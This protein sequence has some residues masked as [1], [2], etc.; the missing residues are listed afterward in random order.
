MTFEGVDHE[1][2]TEGGYEPTM[3]RTSRGPIEMHHYR[4]EHARKAAIFVGGAGG[5]FDTPWRGRLYPVLCR[6]FQQEG[7]VTCLRVRYRHPADLLECTLDVLA[8]VDFLQQQGVARMAV[9]GWSFGGAV[10]VQAA[11]L[12]ERVRTVVTVAT[13]SYGIDAV[14]ELGPRCSVLLLHGQAD[15]TLPSRCSEYAH[16]IAREPKKLIL[17]PESNHG[18]DQYEA[19]P[20]TVHG[21]IT[22]ELSRT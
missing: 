1:P 2:R 8:G 16:Q 17:D 6:Q 19:M 18:L 12:A 22:G 10:V 13:Q 14:A 20:A 5:G 21:W 4:V 9:T 15:E 3:V 11:A 7:Q